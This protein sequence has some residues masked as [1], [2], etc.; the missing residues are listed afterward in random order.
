MRQEQSLADL[1]IGQT[2]GSEPGDLKLLGGQLIA[3]I[4]PAGPKRLAGGAQLL[5]C[6][7]TMFGDSLMF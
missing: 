2:L 1:A 7:S 6:T 4:G 5:P 3:D